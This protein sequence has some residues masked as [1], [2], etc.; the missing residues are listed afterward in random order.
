MSYLALKH[1]HLT[2]IAVT[3]ALFVLRGIW[4]ILDS[5]RLQARWV[6]IVPHVNDTVLLASALALAWQ[7][8]QYPFVDTWL[9]AKVL[10]LLTYIALGIIALRP[11][12]SKGARV[13]AWVLAQVV[14]WYVVTVALTRH[15]IPMAH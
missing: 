13:A 4:M 11:G 15:A 7:I 5:P 6:R 14:F 10:G 8:G 3:Y 9:T 1:T 12:R 2:A